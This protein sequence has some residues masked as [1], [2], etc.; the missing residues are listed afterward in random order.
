MTG[1]EL[2]CPT[3]RLNNLFSIASTLVSKALAIEDSIE[4]VD[5]IEPSID[6]SI[7]S[8]LEKLQTE[9][10]VLQTKNADLVGEVNHLESKLEAVQ[11]EAQTSI[12][13]LTLKLNEATNEIQRQSSE[14]NKLHKKYV[15]LKSDIFDGKVPVKSTT[16]NP[17]TLDGEA[18][19]IIDT[20]QAKERV[21]ELIKQGLEHKAIAEQ[22]ESEGYRTKGLL[23]DVK[24][25]L[26]SNIGKWQKKFKQNGRI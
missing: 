12:D 20:D 7:D 24:P 10:E 4:A 16:R 11:T 9:N 8:T 17:L 2:P 25:Y 13:S 6:S 21:I 19:Y 22:L 1:S 5:F 15:V 23:G 3:S 26:Q 18:E 14:Y